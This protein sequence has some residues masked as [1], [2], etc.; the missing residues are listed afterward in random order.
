MPS[1][2]RA[3]K[4]DDATELPLSLPLSI[5]RTQ[6]HKLEQPNSASSSH[7]KPGVVYRFGAL[8]LAFAP[9]T[10]A[11]AGP[12]ATKSQARSAARRHRGGAFQ[13]AWPDPCVFLWARSRPPR[14]TAHVRRSSRCSLEGWWMHVRYPVG[15]RRSSRSLRSPWR[16]SRRTLPRISARRQRRA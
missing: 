14:R 7:A 13:R 4:A 11:N 9:A 10:A 15:F 8:V 3:A 1:A 2:D 16:Q 12:S 5:S 6:P